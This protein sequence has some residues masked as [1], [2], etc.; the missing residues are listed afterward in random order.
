MTDPRVARLGDV[1]VHHSLKLQAGESVLIEAFDLPPEAVALIAERVLAAGATPIVALRSQVVQR[2][3]LAGATEAAMALTG[4][5]DRYRMAAV[6]AYIGLRGTHNISEMADVPADRMALYTRLVQK[7]VHFELRVPRGRW[8]VLRWPTASMA[9]LAQMSSQ[10]F[11]DFYFDVCTLDYAR[12]SA[13]MEPLVALM[14]R[15]DRVRLTAPGTDLRFSIKDI[16]AIACGGDCNI[17]DGEVFTAPV[18]DSVEGEI[19]FNAPTIYHGVAFDGVRLRF[20]AGKV[21]EATASNTARAN[22]ILDTDEG[23]RYVGEFA[24]GLNPLITRPMRDILFDEKI[25]GSLH[26][27]PG[28]AYEEADNGNRSEAHW[29]LVLLQ[30]AV[31][32]GGEIW[33]DGV[34]VRRDGVFVLPEL[35]GLNP[36]RLLA[37]R[38]DA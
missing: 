26:F 28:Q 37:T 30:D 22:E 19:T 8:V 14:Q 16:P 25:A 4:D 20:E 18:R 15:T 12:L 33:F 32:G 29:D 2:Q 34:L 10:A 38:Q 7:P 6:D 24:I 17:P 9:Q 5:I 21:V 3:L 27:T 23:A 31:H 13:A 1:L 36:E 35:E 11:T